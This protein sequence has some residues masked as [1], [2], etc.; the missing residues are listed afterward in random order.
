MT[1]IF[2]VNNAEHA[3][4]EAVKFDSSMDARS[5]QIEA[6]LM[7]YETM[8]FRKVGSESGVMSRGESERLTRALNES[9]ATL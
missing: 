3:G 7:I 5:A 8:K 4:E 9:C 6:G 2:M 1:A